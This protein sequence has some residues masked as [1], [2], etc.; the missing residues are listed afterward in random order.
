MIAC[1]FFRRRI[2]DLLVK[3]A[4]HNTIFVGKVCREFDE[5]PSTN[6]YAAEWAKDPAVPEGAVVRAA[7]QTAGRGQMGAS[8]YAARGLNLTFSVVFRPRWLPV[9]RQWSLSEAV[10]LAVGD[11]CTDQL[12][13]PVAIKWPNDIWLDGHKTGGIL[14]QNSLQGGEFNTV[15]VGIGLNVLQ[16]EFPPEAPNA[17]SLLLAA[18]RPLELEAVFKNTL[19]HL[20]N[21]YLAL[22]AGQFEATHQA[23]LHR[24]MGLGKV[25]EFQRTADLSVFRA[26]IADVAP[27]G[28]L[29]LQHTDGHFEIFEVKAI[30]W[31]R[32]VSDESAA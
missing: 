18:N 14:I 5:L 27:E 28:P 3:D 30:K 32:L 20:E 16:T 7:F 9:T 13:R 21:R 10:A 4:K 23:Y 15:I 25:S 31:L 6:D 8:W 2:K 1:Q 29:C 24:L 26:R 19:F 11:A 17:T 22:K 12:G